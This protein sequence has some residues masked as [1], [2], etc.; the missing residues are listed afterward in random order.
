MVYLL[1]VYV[2]VV[3]AVLLVGCALYFTVVALAARG[4]ERGAEPLLLAVARAD[5]PPR[6]L[7]APLRVSFVGL[8]WLLLAG[9]GASGAALLLLDGGTAD[10]ARGGVPGVNLATKLIL[11]A[12]L[13]GA[14]LL[15]TARPS[16][17]AAHLVTLLLLAIAGL[18][19]LIGR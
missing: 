3:A 2:H 6:G 11:F 5:F 10:V 15:L 4:E 7:S 18:S 12:L 14:Q 19:A 8:G 13:L 17:R 1:V 9:M 16:P